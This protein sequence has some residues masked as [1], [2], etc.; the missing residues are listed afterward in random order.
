MGYV[1]RTV[2]HGI[3]YGGNNEDAEGVEDSNIDYYS[4]DHNIEGHVITANLQWCF[5]I[6]Y[7]EQLHTHVLASS[8]NSNGPYLTIN[9]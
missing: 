6:R 3:I 7:L 5:S 8:R 2:N 4:V 1:R 9:L